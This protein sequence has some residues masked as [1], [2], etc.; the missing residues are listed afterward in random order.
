M[1]NHSLFGSFYIEEEIDLAK[2]PDSCCLQ[3]NKLKSN[4]IGHCKNEYNLKWTKGCSGKY[5][6]ALF[7]SYFLVVLYSII[8]TVKI[9]QIIYQTYAA[10]YSLVLFKKLDKTLESFQVT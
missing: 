3:F 4:N 7:G 1:K 5:L 10:H 9:F 8:F 6:E 2:L